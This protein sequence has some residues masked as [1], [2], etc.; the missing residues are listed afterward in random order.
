MPIPA[1]AAMANDVPCCEGSADL[2]CDVV[3]ESIHVLD[4][5]ENRNKH[6]IEADRS[7]KKI[8]KH[9]VLVHL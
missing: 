3:K 6:V 8:K 9:F 7:G 4:Q 1:A 5:I 2:E